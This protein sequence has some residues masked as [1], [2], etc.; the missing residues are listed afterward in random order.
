M[1][2][3][4]TRI[5]DAH[6]AVV[7]AVQAVVLRAIEAGELLLQQKAKI[8]HGEWTTWLAQNC[9][10]IH[11]RMAQRYMLLAQNRATLEA[12][13]THVSDLT[14]RGALRLAAGDDFPGTDDVGP[15]ADFEPEHKAA[16]GKRAPKTVDNAWRNAKPG[17]K[18][19]FIKYHAGEITDILGELEEEGQG[20][21]EITLR[22]N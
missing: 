16:K 11:P 12:K 9:P 14:L 6:A 18:K 1:D 4:A 3:L 8:G 2:D 20:F 17:E 13:T 22:P 19:E 5:N 10:A 21:R 7:S 15:C